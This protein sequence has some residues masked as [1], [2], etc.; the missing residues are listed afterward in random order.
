MGFKNL[1]NKIKGLF[2]QILIHRM[3]S[4]VISERGE[5]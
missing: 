1:K 3:L 2:I 4:F 5:V